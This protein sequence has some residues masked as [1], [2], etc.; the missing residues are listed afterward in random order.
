MQA[1]ESTTN[2]WTYVAEHSSLQIRMSWEQESPVDTKIVTTNSGRQAAFRRYRLKIQTPRT[3][4]S[5]EM[6]LT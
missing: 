3:L 6:K 1:P 5:P 2:T 4:P